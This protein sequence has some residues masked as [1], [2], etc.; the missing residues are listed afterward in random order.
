M[1]ELNPCANWITMP[2]NLFISRGY[3][4]IIW[5]WWISLKGW[6]R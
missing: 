2:F 3:I 4:H 6:G 5:L 1:Y